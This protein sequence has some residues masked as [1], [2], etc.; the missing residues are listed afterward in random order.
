MVLT[1]GI[2][3][4]RTRNTSSKHSQ[5]S[6]TTRHCSGV[7]NATPHHRQ[8]TKATQHAHCVELH[9]I[10]NTQPNKLHNTYG[11]EGIRKVIIN[12]KQPSMQ[13]SST[14]V[15]SSKLNRYCKQ[16]V[17]STDCVRAW[18]DR[19]NQGEQMGR[20]ATLCA[21]VYGHKKA[22]R[23]QRR[24]DVQCCVCAYMQKQ[25]KREQTCNVLCARVRA[26]A[27][28]ERAKKSRR[29]MLCPRVR[30]QHLPAGEQTNVLGAQRHRQRHKRLFLH[31]HHRGRVVASFGIRVGVCVR[32]SCVFAWVCER[33]CGRKSG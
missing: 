30:A 25:P 14:R 31:L 5:K 21:R 13:N 29:A 18:F 20:R 32:V 19:G 3:T 11:G 10:V 33:A 27:S 28:S 22:A 4:R 24:A 16:V 15:K 9:I 17:I 12:A 26:Q 8:C 23:E 2:D 6:S 1:E 7:D